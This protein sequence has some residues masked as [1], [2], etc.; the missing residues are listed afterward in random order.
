MS[1]TARAQHPSLSENAACPEGRS[2]LVLTTQP[3]PSPSLRS[4]TTAGSD[5]PWLPN[6]HDDDN[7]HPAL[8]RTSAAKW[9][10][11]LFHR[12]AGRGKATSSDAA[13]F[14]RF[15]NPPNLT[16]SNHPNPELFVR[17]VSKRK[18]GASSGSS[19]PSLGAA[20]RRAADQ[21][22]SYE[23]VDKP[24]PQVQTTPHGLPLKPV[25]EGSLHERYARVQCKSC[26]AWSS[27]AQGSGTSD[28]PHRGSPQLILAQL[29]G[30]GARSWPH[31][32][33]S[34]RKPPSRDN[35]SCRG[36]KWG[37]ICG[38][39]GVHQAHRGRG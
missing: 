10:A 38:K 27:G 2:T 20:L 11:R 32:V 23:H 16:T 31:C 1:P 22:L 30:H 6:R 12:K 13:N 5:Q 8:R 25:K 33:Q 17:A 4:T 18:Q 19:P 24:G 28:F 39:P 34:R 15:S 36:C 7:K 21:E 29:L 35:P 37:A 14:V 26:R 3:A 9:Q